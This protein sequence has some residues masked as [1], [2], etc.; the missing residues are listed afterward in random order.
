[1]NTI[2]LNGTNPTIVVDNYD[3]ET[4]Q[5]IIQYCC[6]NGIP[7]EVVK[8]QPFSETQRVVTGL[9]RRDVIFF[10]TINMANWCLKKTKWLGVWT[11]E[12]FKCSYYYCRFG[13]YLLNN[14]CLFMPL[15]E[16]LRRSTEFF[17]YFGDEIFIR[18]NSGNKSFTGNI[19]TRSG[20]S[21]EI[22]SLSRVPLDDQM[23]I[24]SSKKEIGQEYRLFVFD[25]R[26]VAGSQYH[27]NGCLLTLPE[28]P[29]SVMSYAESVVK[30]VNFGNYV[31]DIGVIGDRI[32]IVELNSV[33]CS[34]MYDCDVGMIIGA[35]IR[36]LRHELEDY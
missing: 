36:S 25:D 35:A 1:M 7:I 34:G 33:T 10:G 11:G 8:Y 30:T 22:K 5:R 6:S 21:Y 4:T 31:L 26:I 23:V 12:Q 16:F 19:L 3:S 27:E 13:K 28:V 24:L 18:P 2:P 29:S 20:I 15:S 14:D 9:D 17:D 32:G